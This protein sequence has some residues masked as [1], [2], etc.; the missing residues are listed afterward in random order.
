[1]DLIHNGIRFIRIWHEICKKNEVHVARIKI[2]IR[3]RTFDGIEVG[4][5]YGLFSSYDLTLTQTSGCFI[6]LESLRCRLSG[7]GSMSLMRRGSD[8]LELRFNTIPVAAM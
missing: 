4:A 3:Q 1:M 6:D 7:S 5:H 8:V 2:V